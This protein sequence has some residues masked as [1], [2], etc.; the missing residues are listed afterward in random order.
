MKAATLVGVLT[1]SAIVGAAQAGVLY[2]A[3]AFGQARL[4]TVDRSTGQST[5]VGFFG[6]ETP[7][8]MAHSTASG[9]TYLIDQSPGARGIFSVHLDTGAAT[10]I[11]SVGSFGA[12]RA[13]GLAWRA[14]TD[15]FY[16]IDYETNILYKVDVSNGTLSNPVPMPNSGGYAAVTYDNNSD[17]LYGIAAVVVGQG[18]GW[19]VARINP[20]TGVAQSVLSLGSGEDWRGLAFDTDRNVLWTHNNSSDFLTA[21]DLS[22]GT[23]TPIGSTQQLGA[24]G[25]SLNA[26]VFVPGPGATWLL[27]GASS[28]ALRRR[29]R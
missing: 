6:V 5:T 19:H 8:G 27:L 11:G 7:F 16:S 28:V 14:S 9:T 29:R 4:T 18:T 3:E 15:S 23:L 13:R 10:R 25:T 1:S 12:V 20:T 17:Q 24:S 21:I 26:L 2:G 22:S